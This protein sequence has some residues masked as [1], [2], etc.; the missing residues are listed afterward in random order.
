MWYFY[1]IFTCAILTKSILVLFLREPWLWIFLR[2]YQ[3]YSYQ[4][5]VS[6][7]LTD[8]LL[9]LFTKKF[10]RSIRTESLL[11]PFLPKIHQCYS[12]ESYL[13]DISTCVTAA[14]LLQ[15]V[16]TVDGKSNWYFKE[17][18]KGNTTCISFFSCT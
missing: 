18:L 10:T 8:Y 17:T 11:A 7:I 5:I 4:K 9:M 16:G 15:T 14:V 3:C 12:Y 13:G 1:L 2:V 6:S